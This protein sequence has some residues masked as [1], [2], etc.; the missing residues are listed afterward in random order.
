M[1]KPT[2]YGE[3]MQLCEVGTGKIKGLAPLTL[4]QK[5]L[6]LCN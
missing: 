1:N 2:F 4:P 3:P 5:C 6:G